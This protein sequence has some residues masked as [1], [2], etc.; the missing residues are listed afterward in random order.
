MYRIA[1]FFAG[2]AGIALSVG[3]AAADIDWGKVDQA[4]GKPGTNQPGGVHKFG[5][6]RSDL[7]VTVDGVAIYPTLALGSWIVFMSMSTGAMFMLDL[8]LTAN[9]IT[10][11]MTRIVTN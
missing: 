6:P 9:A 1:P 7:K 8:V 2:I 5:L 3:A 11:L 4:L 10:H